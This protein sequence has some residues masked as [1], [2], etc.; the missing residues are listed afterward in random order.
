MIDFPQ[1]FYAAIEFIL[2]WDA[3]DRIPLKASGEEST[4]TIY[5]LQER[6]P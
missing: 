2:D 6:Q 4:H 1:H 5:R 3:C